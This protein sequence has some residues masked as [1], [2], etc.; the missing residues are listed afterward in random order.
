MPSITGL[1]ANGP[2]LPSPSTAVPFDTTPTRLLRA[3]KRAAFSGFS[4]IASHANATPGEYASE[5]SR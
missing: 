5:R 2:I 3:V 4:T 1:E